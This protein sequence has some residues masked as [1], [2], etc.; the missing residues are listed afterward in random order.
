MDEAEIKKVWIDYD[1]GADVLYM[2][3][4]YPP[5]AVEHEEDENGIIR[6]YDERGELTGLTIMEAK[7]LA[8]EE[9]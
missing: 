3:F 9:K 6:N 1:V 8:Q 2:S 5:N 7:R 4:V